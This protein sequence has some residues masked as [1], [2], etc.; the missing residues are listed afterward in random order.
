VGLLLAS[1]VHGNVET[2]LDTTGAAVAG[3]AA[4]VGIG[5]LL[6]IGG[7]LRRRR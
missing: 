2:V 6:A 3:L 4:G 7:L 1:E 5:L